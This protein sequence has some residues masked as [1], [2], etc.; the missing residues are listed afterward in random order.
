MQFFIRQNSTLP[1]LK[2]E[3][4]RDSNVSFREIYD[5]LIGSTLTF[6]MKDLSND[7]YVILND[8]ASIDIVKDEN[9][10][11]TNVFIS[12]QFS[13]K[14]TKRIGEFIGEFKLNYLGKSLSLPL[15][16]NLFI[17]VVE[18]ISNPDLC[19]KPNRDKISI[20]PN[21][22]QPPTPSPTTTP[23]PTV[24]PTATPT[25]TPSVTATPSITPTVTPSITPIS[26]PGIPPPFTL[27]PTPT[28]SFDRQNFFM[29][30]VSVVKNFFMECVSVIVDIP[31][32]PPVTPTVTPTVTPS[33]SQCILEHYVTPVAPLITPTPSVTPTV[34]PSES[35]CI[36]EHYVTPV[37]PLI[38]PTPSVTPTVTPSESQCILE[39]YVTPVAPLITPTPSPSIR[40]K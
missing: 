3:I 2:V 19:C 10:N 16:N 31:V 28:P 12:Y 9:D 26:S 29:K 23:T 39:H 18:S 1:I 40:I 25:T 37:A 33:E 35:Q 11:I 15:E 4:I 32:T 20:V 30:C 8:L 17:N 21:L 22:S 34:T 7:R 24:T 14:Q 5:G 27:T 36:L 13:K 6:S 38:T